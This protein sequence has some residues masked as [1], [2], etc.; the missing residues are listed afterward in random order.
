MQP[1]P[2]PQT[3]CVSQ[4]YIDYSTRAFKEV[5]AQRD[6]VAKLVEEGKLDKADLSIANAIIASLKSLDAINVQKV[7]AY[8]EL[9]KIYENIIKIQNNLIEMLEK[10]LLKPKSMFDK[11]MDILKT[12]TILVGGI[13]IGHG[14]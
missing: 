12:V 11:F 3:V 9:T 2:T 4:S 7:N 5:V 14:L 8:I 6:L 1:T 13:V 10:R